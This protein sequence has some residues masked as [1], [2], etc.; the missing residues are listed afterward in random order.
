MAVDTT[1][2]FPSNHV[3]W[4]GDGFGL[5][6]H[7]ID[8]IVLGKA[9]LKLLEE[10]LAD[11]GTLFVDGVVEGVGEAIYTLTHAFCLIAIFDLRVYA[12]QL[13]V[14]VGQ[15]AEHDAFRMTQEEEVEG[16]AEW[17]HLNFHIVVVG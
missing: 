6:P 3:A 11:A 15:V 2:L 1:A 7:A 13:V 14:K 5:A 10:G 12:Q 4:Y 9:G 8:D 16:L 17:G